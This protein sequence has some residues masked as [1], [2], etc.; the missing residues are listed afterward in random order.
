VLKYAFGNYKQNR[1]GGLMPISQYG[2]LGSIPGQS[3]WDL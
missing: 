3:M 2:G 1:S